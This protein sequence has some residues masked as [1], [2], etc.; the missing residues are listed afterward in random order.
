MGQDGDGQQTEDGDEHGHDGGP[1]GIA[2]VDVE[3]IQRHAGGT[4]GDHDAGVL[5][6]DESDEQSD[7]GGDGHLDLL[8]DALEDQLPETGDGEEQEDQAVHQDQHQG[9]GI[10][11]THAQADGVDEVGV[12][13]H[14]GGLAPAADWTGVR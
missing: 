13:A 2:G 12:E 11:E 7:T 6:A 8:G 9:I 10:G 5:E 4:V 3:G 1:G 14:A